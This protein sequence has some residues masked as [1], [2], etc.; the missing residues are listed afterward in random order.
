[1]HKFN[2]THRQKLIKSDIGIS[3][4][5]NDKNLCFYLHSL[6][7]ERYEFPE[8]AEISLEAKRLTTHM[9]FSLGTIANP[10]FRPHKNILSEFHDPSEIQFRVK[11]IEPATGMLLGEVDNLKAGSPNDDESGLGDSLLPIM[12]ENL[13]DMVWF[14]D[15][16]DTGP[17][18]LINSNQIKSDVSTSDSFRALVFPQIIYQ[19]F[20]HIYYIEKLDYD[21][22]DTDYWVQLW[23]KFAIKEMGS[24]TLPPPIDAENTD[25][26]DWIT[27][28]TATFAKRLDCNRLYTKLMEG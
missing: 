1:M 24:Q 25:I 18:L 19:I 27:Q 11:I 26:K 14:L 4:F 20:T 5:V 21:E 12:S 9:Q 15:M 13:E 8:E 28:A 16:T 3:T 17:V 2:Y 7:L 22:E 10:E 6:D 23:Y